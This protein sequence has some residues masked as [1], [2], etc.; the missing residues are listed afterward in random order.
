MGK[1]N[2]SSTKMDRVIQG[3]LEQTSVEKAA[4]ASGV[5]EATI[6]RWLR[7]P[8]F[9]QAYAMA[10]REAFSR[11]LARLQHASSAAVATLLR[12]MLD[13]DSPAASKVRAAD[14]VLAH[15]ATAF[16]LEDIEFRLSRLES[17]Q[18]AE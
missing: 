8:E 10:R 7:K 15:A 13:R 2:S 3:L 4:I 1:N 6:W 11:S 16:E 18:E 5:S 17:I 12:V 14:C 9:R